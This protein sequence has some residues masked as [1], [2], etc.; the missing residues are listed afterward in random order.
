MVLDLDLFRSDKGHDP[1]KIRENQTKRFKDLN[2]VETVIAKD[3]E[4]RSCR[5]R[6]DNWNKL[7]N[8]CSKEIGEKMKKKQAPGNESDPVPD[9]VIANLETVTSEQLKALTVNQIKKVRALI[10]AAVIE[11]EKNLIDAENVR[12]AALRE[13]G[14]HLHESVPVSDNEDENKVERTFGDCT[15]KT[16]YSHVDLIHMIDGMN[17]EKGTVVS[18]GRGYFL[19]GAAVFLEQALIQFALH[20]L[21]DK[22][23]TPLYTPF[24][25]RKEVMFTNRKFYFISFL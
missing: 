22:G 3:S 8:V 1:N 9:D 13:V 17:G 14:N 5:H 24:F 12:N 10:D 25:M 15:A 18:G 20:T 19:T 7:K 4:W 16:K 23:Y 2:L 21:H 6:A 11:N